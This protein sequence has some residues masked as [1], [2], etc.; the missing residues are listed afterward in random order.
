MRIVRELFSFVSHMFRAVLQL[1][2]LFS[3]LQSSLNCV[4]KKGATVTN[5]FNNA[6]V[7]T[8]EKSIPVR[9]VAFAC[10]KPNAQ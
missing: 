9:C 10:A 7:N 2:Q 3:S 8:P 1:T 4:G 5:Y 6:Q